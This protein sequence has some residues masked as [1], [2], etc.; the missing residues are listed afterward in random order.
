MP[1]LDLLN[2]NT[3]M[4]TDF[5]GSYLRVVAIDFERVCEH[6]PQNRLRPILS[7][8]RETWD[9]RELTF[10]KVI[11]KLTDVYE[12]LQSQLR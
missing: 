9:Y 8:T 3:N 5:V 11:E 7:R 1:T 4:A 6:I 10:F 12:V 2:L